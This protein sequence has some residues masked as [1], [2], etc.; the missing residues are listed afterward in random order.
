MKARLLT[1]EDARRSHCGFT[2]PSLGDTGVV[3]G[4][5]KALRGGVDRTT[6]APSSALNWLSGPQGKRVRATGGGSENITTAFHSA[7]KIL[8][9]SENSLF[10]CNFVFSFTS[11]VNIED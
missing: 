10:A 2:L 11:I 7:L 1:T 6:S 3:E 8:G 9:F 5:R 4:V